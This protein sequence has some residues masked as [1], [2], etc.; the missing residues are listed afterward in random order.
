MTV[1]CKICGREVPSYLAWMSHWMQAVDTHLD[2]DGRLWKDVGNVW[3]C[4]NCRVNPP[5][6]WMRVG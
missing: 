1:R 2:T 5:D 3:A 6:G 4:D